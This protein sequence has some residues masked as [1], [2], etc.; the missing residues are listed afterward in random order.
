MCV[1]TTAIPS[2]LDASIYIN[3][4][5]YADVPAGVIRVSEIN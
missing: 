1:R 5:V 3:V 4:S 2:V